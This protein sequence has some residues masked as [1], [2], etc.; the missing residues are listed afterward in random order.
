MKEGTERFNLRRNVVWSVVAFAINIGLVFV[1]YRLVIRHSGLEAVGLWSALYAWTTMIR[2]GDAGMANASLHFVATCDPRSEQGRLRAYV[3]T[4]IV[5]NSCLFLLLGLA[6]YLVLSIN[7]GSLVDARFVAQAAGVL[8]VM[9][10]GFVLMNIAG[11]LFGAL[12]GLHLGY[13]NARL[14]IAGNLL[15][16]AIVVVLV[17]RLGIAGLAWAQ[18]AQHGLTTIA[19]WLLVRRKAGIEAP[20]PLGFSIAAFREMLTFSVK[21]QVAN[22]ANG[23]FEPFSK[24]L[25]GHYGGLHMLGVYELAY[26]TVALSRNLVASALG[27]ALPAMTSLMSRNVDEAYALYRRS[28]R[29]NL[30]GTCLVFSAV[31]VATPVISH[32]WIGNLDRSYVTY[33][34]IICAGFVLNAYGAPAYILG[35]A[36]GRMENNIL[37]AVL[38]V[39]LLAASG[40]MLGYVFAADGVVIATG[41]CLAVCGWLIKVRNEKLLFDG[42]PRAYGRAE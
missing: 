19:A 31:I 5:A 21:A 6:G 7:L 16:I 37:T 12:Q 40:T 28:S 24:I 33:T 13:L 23:L 27:A 20:L 9:M 32:I 8:P 2:I 22:I 3:E 34:A 15:Q 4:G 17:P 36:S 11:V 25:V 41:L 18:V 10:A 39:F 26:K 30:R 1:S 29:G 35:M 38:S 14:G 42:F